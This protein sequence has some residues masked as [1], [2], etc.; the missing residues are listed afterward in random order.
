M[1]HRRH[2][3]LERGLALALALGVP[4]AMAA[5]VVPPAIDTHLR[6][7]HEISLLEARRAALV[8]RR[9]DLGALEALRARLEAADPEV[10][11]VLVAETVELARVE[12]QRKVQEVAARNGAILAE[13]RAV[14]ADEE[15]IAQ[16][17]VS[18]SLPSRALPA[19]L[20]DLANGRPLVFIDSLSIRREAWSGGGDAET[21]LALDLL[22]SARTLI[23]GG[24]GSQ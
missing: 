9:R 15:G 5:M 23:G 12:I 14:D 24:E 3:A 22:L 16:A 8:E 2:G 7:E 20:V 6:A 21:I 4:T 10:Y 17:A 19:L 1:S 13:A 11:G 18:L